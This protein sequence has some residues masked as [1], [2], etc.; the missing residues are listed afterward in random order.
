MSSVLPL[1]PPKS[2]DSSTTPSS[3]PLLGFFDKDKTL[4]SK[5]SLDNDSEDQSE[6]KMPSNSAQNDATVE[7]FPSMLDSEDYDFRDRRLDYAAMR[8]GKSD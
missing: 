7:I 5:S 3:T 4:D 2:E 8:F 6:K 1:P